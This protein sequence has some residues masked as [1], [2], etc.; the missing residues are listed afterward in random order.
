MSEN[1]Q[2]L[3]V[4]KDPVAGGVGCFLQDAQLLQLLDSGGGGVVADAQRSGGALDVDNGVLI[5]GSDIIPTPCGLR[6]PCDVVF[7]EIRQNFCADSTRPLQ[8]C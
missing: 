3:F 7:V 5:H 1:L 8:R 2:V 4:G 6:Q